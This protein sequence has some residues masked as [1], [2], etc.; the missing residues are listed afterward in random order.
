MQYIAGLIV[1]GIAISFSIFHLK[2]DFT[3]YFDPVGIAVVLGGTLAV[4]TIILPWNLLTEI[5]ETFKSLLGNSR[6]DMKTL[7]HECFEMIKTAHSGHAHFDSNQQGYIAHQILHDG[8][9]LIQLG[10]HH[11]KINHIL[12]ERIYQW[13]ERK[14][15]VANA[16]RSLAK[17]PP[18]FGLVGTVLG[19]MSLMRAISDGASSTETGLRMAVALVATLYGLLTANLIINPAGENVLKKTNDEKKAAELALQAVLLASQRANLLESQETLNSYVSHQD[20]IST[21][22][23]HESEES[24][25]AAA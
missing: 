24:S 3:H 19:L 10:F 25:G 17:Y 1:A 4:A 14:Q 7:N 12:D 8:A 23:Q 22:N 5:K 21:F 13:A 9:E 20:R 15:K 16:I 18:A 6:V 2:Q 11:Q